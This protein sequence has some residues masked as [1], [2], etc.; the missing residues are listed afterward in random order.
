MS[1]WCQVCPQRPAMAVFVGSCGQ[2]F[3]CT[4]RGIHVKEFKHKLDPVTKLGV[5]ISHHEHEF[6]D[7]LDGF[8]VAT[9]HTEGYRVLLR[10]LLKRVRNDRVNSYREHLTVWP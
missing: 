1:A 5:T 4:S 2:V 6:T 3:D 10:N 8:S 9:V 7:V